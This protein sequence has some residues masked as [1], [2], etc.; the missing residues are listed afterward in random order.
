[1]SL[2]T[3]AFV[4]HCRQNAISVPVLFSP[5][6]LGV[7]IAFGSVAVSRFGITNMHRPL[8]PPHQMQKRFYANFTN[9]RQLV[10]FVSKLFSPPGRI[11]TASPIVLYSFAYLNR[12]GQ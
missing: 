12:Q 6:G 8:N 5:P 1:V 3:S 2:L 11:L 7:A 4:H 10:Q 9:L